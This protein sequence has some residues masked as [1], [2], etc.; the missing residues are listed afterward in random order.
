MTGPTLI[1]LGDLTLTSSDLIIQMCSLQYLPADL[2][3]HEPHAVLTFHLHVVFEA[4]VTQRS[5]DLLSHCNAPLKS[6]CSQDSFARLL[7]H[8]TADNS[9]PVPYTSASGLRS[10]DD[11]DLFLLITAV[12]LRR[13]PTS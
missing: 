6:F 4:T 11:L 5:L 12:L 1:S 10:S 8:R 7:T 3:L 9:L 2:K 13:L